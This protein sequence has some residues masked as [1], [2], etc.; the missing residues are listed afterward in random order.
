MIALL[1][2]VA[3]G[4]LMRSSLHVLRV[5]PGFDAQDVVAMTMSLPARYASPAQRADFY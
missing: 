4:L 1:L 2:L 3:S 5:D